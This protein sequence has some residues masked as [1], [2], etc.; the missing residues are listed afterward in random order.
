M[1][2]TYLIYPN[3]GGKFKLGSNGLNIMTSN[4]IAI[5]FKFV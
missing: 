1:T 4:R 5:D 2:K 3:G